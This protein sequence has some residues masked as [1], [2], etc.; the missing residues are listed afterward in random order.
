[1]TVVQ[2][3]LNWPRL[4]FVVLRLAFNSLSS[5]SNLTFYTLL[6]LD[7]TLFLDFSKSI[8]VFITDF[9]RITV[10]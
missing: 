3:A 1:M 7:N 5:S 4:N 2:A 8:F 9:F 10:M 6:G